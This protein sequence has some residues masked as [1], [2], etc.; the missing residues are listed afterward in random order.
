MSAQRYT[1]EFKIE[2]VNQVLGRGHSVAE[3]AQRLGVSQH[4]LYQWIKQRRQPV[5][6]P[7]GQ[8]SQSDEVRRL[9]AEL[10]R[11]TEERDILKNVWSA[12]V[13][14]AV[15]ANVRRTFC[16]NVSGLRLGTL[17]PGL[18]GIRARLAS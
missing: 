3:V 4:S 12:P 14:Q 8:I 6:Q 11:V 2:A 18:D 15:F 10:K 1:E 7:Q 13:L 5:A 17:V 16:V 9:K